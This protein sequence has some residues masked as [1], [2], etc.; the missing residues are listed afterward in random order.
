MPD[1]P[2]P[3]TDTLRQGLESLQMALGEDAQRRLLG[4]LALIVRWNRVYNLTAVRDP[5]TMLS[6]HLMDSLAVLPALRSVLQQRAQALCTEA[7]FEAGAG[8]PRVLDVGSGAG[9]PGVVLAVVEPRWHITCVD[10]V[11]KKASFIRQVAAEL[12][13]S[14][15]QA[16]HARV[17]DVSRSPGFDVVAS[18]AFAS[19]ADFV[20]LTR[21][22]V[23]P[24]GC[25]MA[26]KGKLP[27]DE[28]AA[29]PPDIEVF[30]V[31]QLTVPGLVAQRCLIW[32]RKRSP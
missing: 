20:S 19:L 32:M 3:L 14:N 28:L 8:E 12:G 23:N 17:E 9:L 29:L 15:L 22:L 30:H 5:D 2:A 7:Q 21:H 6:H 25:W 27:E 4:H 31:E 18:R 1:A 16:L 24:G 11:A 26:M 10:A 13:L